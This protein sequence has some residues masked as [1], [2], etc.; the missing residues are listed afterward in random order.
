ML[1]PLITHARKV[2]H[3][4]RETRH[5]S[6]NGFRAFPPGGKRICVC[7]SQGSKGR[8]QPRPRVSGIPTPRN[9]FSLKEVSAAIPILSAGGPGAIVSVFM[10][11]LWGGGKRH[12]GFL[13]ASPLRLRG[14]PSFFPLS[15]SP[16]GP[17]RHPR[18]WRPIP[19]EVYGHGRTH[20]PRREGGRARTRQGH[21]DGSEGPGKGKG[22]PGTGAG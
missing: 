16:R 4:Q 6:E 9:R 20:R 8:E 19:R 13:Q 21:G 7:P 5:N 1:R 22:R 12:P 14:S 18:F 17:P 10:I 15:R 3:H 2:Q 11:L